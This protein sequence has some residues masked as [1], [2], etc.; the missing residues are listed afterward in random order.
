MIGSYDRDKV[1]ELLAYISCQN[2]HQTVSKVDMGLF[3]DNRL[4][5]TN[6]NGKKTDRE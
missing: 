6:R 2:Y 5:L 4:I 3:W 1:C